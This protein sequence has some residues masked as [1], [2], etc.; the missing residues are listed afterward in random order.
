MGYHQKKEEAKMAFG[1][2]GGATC[3]CEQKSIGA[4][5]AAVVVQ[6]YLIFV[7]FYSLANFSRCCLTFSL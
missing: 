6:Y 7:D 2:V 4:G 5:L 3:G 1:N